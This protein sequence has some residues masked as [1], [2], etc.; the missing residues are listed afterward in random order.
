MIQETAI[1]STVASID[2]VNGIYDNGSY[3]RIVLNGGALLINKYQIKTIDTIRNDTVRI[4]IGE[5]PLRNI[6]IKLADVAVPAGLAD[7]AALRDA[8]VAMVNISAAGMD[9]TR[10]DA[11]INELTQIRNLLVTLSAKWQQ[12][13]LG[14][15]DFA[16]KM[17]LREDESQPGIVYKGFAIPSASTNEPVWA[18]VRIYKQDN[19]LIYQWADGNQLY[20]NIWDNHLNLVY[21]ATSSVDGPLLDVLQAA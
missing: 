5:G 6:Y 14:G 8:V 13:E 19:Q 9:N 21:T 20:D 15:C 17:P 12:G 4:N 11:G 16:C 1:I 10:L 7:A 2:Y 3:L 18:I